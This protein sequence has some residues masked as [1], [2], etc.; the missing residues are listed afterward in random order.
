MSAHT[1]GIVINPWSWIRCSR[2]AQLFS[3][4]DPDVAKDWSR[5]W[6]CQQKQYEQTG[7]K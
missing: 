1:S 2:C 5:C 4:V 3:R 7:E 6:E